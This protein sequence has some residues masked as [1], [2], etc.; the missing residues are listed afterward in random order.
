MTP[1]AFVDSSYQ[2]LSQHRDTA[3]AA[4]MKAYM[5]HQFEFFG[6][7]SPQRKEIGKEILQQ[8]GKPDINDMPEITELIWTYKEREFHYF[9]LDLLTKYAKKAPSEFINLY[10][11]IMRNDQWWDSID[12]IASNLVGPLFKSYPEMIVPYTTKWTKDNNFWVRRVALLFQLK[13][14][15]D[16]DFELLQRLISAN[17]GSSEFF[18][19][20]AIGW[21]LRE[22]AKGAPDKVIEFVEVNSD[23][24]ANLSKREALKNL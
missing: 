13:Y 8:L 23:R 15:G 11:Y 18:I 6:I 2:L 10:E 19:N 22:Y 7:R 17:F 1:K 20:K 16:T 3:D 12:H 24:L 14:K 9:Q 4:L 5:K 21:A